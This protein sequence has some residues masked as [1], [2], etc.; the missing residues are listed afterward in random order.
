M[1]VN[2]NIK[3]TVRGFLLTAMF[4]L[5]AFLYSVTAQTNAVDE[6]ILPFE[7]LLKRPV[8]LRHDL[9]GKHPRLFF[10]AED[11]PKMRERAK[12]IDRELWLA[13][14]KDIQT[15]KR[16]PP[17]P[18]DEDLYKSGLDKRKAGSISQYEF[19]FQI[20]QTSYA[21]AVESDEK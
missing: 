19:A 20:A 1:S 16:N 14:L 6:K 13:T 9:A 11:L 4:L 8:K 12:G 3:I 5:T 2:D 17:D 18:K 7:E 21:Y 10:T 15:L